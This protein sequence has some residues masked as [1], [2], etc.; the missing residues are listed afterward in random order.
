MADDEPA[1]SP[2]DVELE[3]IAQ[4]QRRRIEKKLKGEYE[5]TLLHLS[6]I[7]GD[8]LDFPLTVSA[9]RVDGAVQTRGSFLESITRPYLPGD[10]ATLEDVLHSARGIARVIERSNIF[11]PASTHIVRASHPQ[12]PANAVDILVTARERGR[13]SVQTQTEFGAN[14]GGVSLK[15]QVRNVFGGAETFD[16]NLSSGTT[17]TRSFDANL[18]VPLSNDLLTRGTVSLVSNE[19]DVRTWASCIEGL[20][21]IR[22]TLVRGSNALTYEL[23]QRNIGSLSEHASLAM[24]EEAGTSLKSSLK[25]TWMYDTRD[26]KIA[27]TSGFFVKSIQ[28]LAGTGL[29]GDAQ[30]WKGE[31]EYQI[32]RK[33]F[34]GVVSNTPSPSY[35]R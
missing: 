18:S 30:F 33:L 28:E 21:G 11:H 17:T 2:A 31:F 8:N 10:G 27:G 23:M 4:W 3:K 6:Q 16:I 13:F 20:R 34:W 12:A 19:R 35:Y 15:G 7:V 14:E 25:H 29:G 32:S 22:A 24:R 26:D 1:K 5:S 9:V